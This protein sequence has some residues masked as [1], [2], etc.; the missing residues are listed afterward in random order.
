MKQPNL[1]P[2]SINGEEL[3][4][5][6]EDYDFT[7]LGHREVVPRGYVCDGA[8]VPR[9]AWWFLPPDG[10]HRAAAYE[11]DAMYDTRGKLE[12]GAIVTKAAVD[13]HFANRLRELGTI[14]ECRIKIIYYAVH[15][16][17]GHAWKT[18]DGTRLILPIKNATPSIHFKR[19]RNP[20][21]PRHI[22][23]SPVLR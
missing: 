8:S 22:Y 10:T 3:Y 4:Q 19:E 21:R 20:F 23:A 5:S 2:I 12:D 13:L 17:G 11:H 14:S 6:L 16:F 9:A 15:Q 1:I 7:I 18:G